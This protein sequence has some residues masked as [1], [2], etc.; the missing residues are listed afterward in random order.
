VTTAVTTGKAY[1]RVR[2]T[3]IA[4]AGLRIAVTVPILSR[5][6]STRYSTEPAAASATG[7]R[8]LVESL[9]ANLVDNAIRHNV[10]GGRVTVATGAAGPATRLRVG[11]TGPVISPDELGRL[12]EPFRRRTGDRTSHPDGH[13][14]GLAIVRAIATAHRARLELDPRADGGLD[15]EVSFH[16]TP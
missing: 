8:R 15:V 7:D 13:G 5:L 3:P 14:L 2:T 12:V 4:A 10:R 11:N 6:T 9:A 16:R 1:S